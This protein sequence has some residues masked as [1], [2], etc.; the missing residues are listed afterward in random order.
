MAGIGR[1]TVAALAEIADRPAALE[2]VTGVVAV[3]GDSAGGTL[4]AL[5]CLRLRFERPAALPD[6]QVLLYANTDL[7]GACPSMREK[8]P[9]SD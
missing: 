4:A 3:A 8:P 7:T 6:V 5:A 9:A 1:D 2:P